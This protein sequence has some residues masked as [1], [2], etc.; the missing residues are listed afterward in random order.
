MLQ[1]FREFVTPQQKELAAKVEK[2]GGDA[3]L[4]NEQAMKELAGLETALTAS[5]GQSQ[6]GR[7]RRFN[8]NELQ[9]EIKSDPEEV[10]KKNTEFFD[11]KFDIQR[12]Q[13]VEDVARTVGREGDR[14]ISAVTSGPHDRIIDPVCPVF[15]LCAAHISPGTQDIY[16][17]WRDMVCVYIV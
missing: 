16:S 10:I 13:I 11:R 12:R 4:E 5:P 9:Q 1:L 8:F 3:V 6:P 17:I 2:M 15:E 14:I 7:D